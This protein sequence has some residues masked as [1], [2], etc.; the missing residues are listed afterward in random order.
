MKKL[1]SMLLFGLIS[2]T[3]AWNSQSLA[4][5]KIVITAGTSSDMKPIFYLDEQNKLTGFD[6]EV[7]NEVFKRLSDYELRWETASPI[8]SLFLGLDSNKYQLIVHNFTKTAEREE[9]YLYSSKPYNNNYKVIVTR[10]G[11]PPIEDPRKLAGKRVPAS[12]GSQPTEWM[13][14]L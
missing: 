13:G 11:T 2:L 3:I 1:F 14:G 7:I 8:A 9:K 12:P 6:V 10:E 5:G 4:K